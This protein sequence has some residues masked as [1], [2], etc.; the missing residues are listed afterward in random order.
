M[1]GRQFC[2]IRRSINSIDDKLCVFFLVFTY[3]IVIIVGSVCFVVVVFLVE[4]MKYMI[5]YRWLREVTGW[6]ANVKFPK[7]E[8]P[9]EESKK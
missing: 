6:R 3:N 5:L 1:H 4:F 9:R 8:H 7:V 2:S